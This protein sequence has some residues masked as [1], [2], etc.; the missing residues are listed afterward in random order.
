V[1]IFHESLSFPL[2]HLP[3]G[4]E[5][6]D[7]YNQ[8]DP[9]SLTIAQLWAS[10]PEELGRPDAILLASPHASNESDYNFVKSGFQSPQKFVHTLPSVRIAP[11]CQLMGWQGPVLCVQKDP[12]TFSSAL[13]ETLPLF[14]EWKRIWVVGLLKVSESTYDAILFDVTAETAPA[15]KMWKGLD[16]AQV[17]SR[18]KKDSWN[19]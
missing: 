18:V 2:T 12:F 17:W 11:L 4:I 6:V 16:D 15:V 10:R 3:K 14:G 8:L 19:R 5:Q 9:A 13:Q 1:K 7:H